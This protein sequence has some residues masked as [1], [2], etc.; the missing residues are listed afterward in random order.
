MSADITTAD[1]LLVGPVECHSPEG[2]VRGVMIGVLDAAGDA[3]G[4]FTIDPVGA[5]SM[6]QELLEAAAA[7]ESSEELDDV[8]SADV[9]LS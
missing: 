8:L 9:R 7:V 6:A 1:Y 3:V 5:R 4:F 2:P